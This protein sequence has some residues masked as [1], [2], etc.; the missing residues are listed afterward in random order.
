MEVHH[1]FFDSKSKYQYA[2]VFCKGLNNLVLPN[3][4]H[5]VE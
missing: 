1:Y 3:L 5:K 2:F 4:I